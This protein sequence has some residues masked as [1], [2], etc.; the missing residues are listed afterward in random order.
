MSEKKLPAQSMD[1]QFA[2]PQAEKSQCAT[3]E[4]R[5]RDTKVG[6]RVIT[7][8]DKNFCDQYETKPYGVV[9]GDAHCGVYE[10]ESQG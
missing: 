6:S 10:K 8:W 4:F 1:M 7:G 3:C 9:F 5:M 2:R